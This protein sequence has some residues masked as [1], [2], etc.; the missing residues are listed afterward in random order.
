MIPLAVQILNGAIDREW[1]IEK[2]HGPS[3]AVKTS[4]KNITF[5]PSSREGCH[6]RPS[7]PTFA[8][9]LD[10]SPIHW[11]S[12]IINMSLLSWRA[13]PIQAAS[14]FYSYADEVCVR[15]KTLPC[16]GAANTRAPFMLN[17]GDERPRRNCL[18]TSIA[19]L[20]ENSNFFFTT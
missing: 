1:N 5:H 18:R 10:A 11:G 8:N 7:R 3:H 14:F 2:A 9:L 13:F 6:D 20:G 16:G 12:G 4:A 19:R 17:A 15:Q